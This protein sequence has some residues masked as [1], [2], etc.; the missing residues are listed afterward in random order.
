MPPDSGEYKIVACTHSDSKAPQALKPLLLGCLRAVLGPH[1]ASDRV[2]T[3]AFKG[4]IP[5]RSDPIE[6]V[7]AYRSGYTLWAPRICQIAHMGAA[8]LYPR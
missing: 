8:R 4:P 7:A 6:T 5:T 3:L 1:Y 2:F